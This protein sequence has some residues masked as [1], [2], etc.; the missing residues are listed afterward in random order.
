M[1]TF[2]AGTN[3]VDVAVTGCTFS[4]HVSVFSGGGLIATGDG[5]ISVSSSKLSGNV[6][7]FGGG[8]IYASSSAATNGLILK[9]LTVTGNFAA[10]SG[11]GGGGAVQINATPDF[12][13]IGGSF[14]NNRASIGGGLC[15]SDSSGSVTGVT[16]TGNTAN[17][18]GGVS[19]N[20]TGTI[21][22]QVAKVHGNTAPTNPEVDGTFS[23]V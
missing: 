20:G 2:G 22:L 21:T 10:T 17:V 9:N 23:F 7:G 14:T 6:S 13:V 5:Q 8:G 15:A 16:I 18:G 12:H 1:S 3:K 11:A 4:N 19:Q